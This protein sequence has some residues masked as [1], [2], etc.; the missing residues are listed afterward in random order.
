MVLV[1]FVNHFCNC[2]N[3][4]VYS[5]QDRRREE[6]IGTLG[7]RRVL[8]AATIVYGFAFV[9]APHHRQPNILRVAEEGMDD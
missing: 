6:G 1:D 5:V 3:R 2:Q 8:D 7:L 9:V 4:L